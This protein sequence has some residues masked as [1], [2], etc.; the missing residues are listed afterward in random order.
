MADAAAAAA[1]QPAPARKKRRRHTVGPLHEPTRAEATGAGAAAA[2]A[3][4][5]R[6]RAVGADALWDHSVPAPVGVPPQTTLRAVPRDA[7]ALAH[8]EVS[9]AHALD[10]LRRK[11]H[12]LCA[13]ESLEAP[14][15]L[16]FERWRFGCK[17]QARARSRTC[18]PAPALTAAR[19][20]AGG[21]SGGGCGRRGG[22][23]EAQ[24]AAGGPGGRERRAA[25]VRA[26]R[27]RRWLGG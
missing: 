7:A 13:A 22:E 4:G 16:A 25:A 2:A 18:H 23:R 8:L 6:A 1:L 26:G 12:D 9:R 5:R 14:P 20:A 24:A 27:R 15:Q 17:L 19:F 3:A 11:L 21:A 10:R